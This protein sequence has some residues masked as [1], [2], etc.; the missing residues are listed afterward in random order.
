MNSTDQNYRRSIELLTV[1]NRSISQIFNDN[2]FVTGDVAQV[3]FR[4]CDVTAAGQYF[5]TGDKRNKLLAIEVVR[6]F[7]DLPW[8]DYLVLTIPGVETIGI[9]REDVAWLIDKPIPGEIPL[10]KLAE[11][12]AMWKRFLEYFDNPIRRGGLA[13]AFRGAHGKRAAKRPL[14]PPEDL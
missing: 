6:W 2:L 4:N 7:R 10:E 5:E 12:P 1:V 13:L 8:M 11:D 3:H 14:V 9:R